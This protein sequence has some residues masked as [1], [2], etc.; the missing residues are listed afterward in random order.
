M[1]NSV[2]QPA[3]RPLASDHIATEIEKAIIG[4]GLRPGAKLAL[5][6]LAKQFNV[7]MIPVREAL[8]RLSAQGLITRKPNV[9]TFVVELTMRE[10]E[11]ILEIRIPL[12]GL[13]ARFAAS[14]SNPADIES[15]RGTVAK[16]AETLSNGDFT[17]YSTQDV[18][19]HQKLWTCSQNP[20]LEKAL[21]TMMN[22]WFGFQLASGVL[23][24]DQDRSII[25]VL[26]GR[27]VDAVESG[28]GD[29]AER[30]I[31]EL[32]TCANS[33]IQDK[34]SPRG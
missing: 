12:E 29:R 13:A 23:A 7:S 6:D 8:N 24:R 28:D 11:Q 33:Y 9:G 3:L 20:F 32:S 26:H 34:L 4:G 27:I 25:P 10:M 5:N 15:L 21:A 17:A 2:F 19:F 14:R 30:S 31:A 22:P 16:M 1:N 18:K